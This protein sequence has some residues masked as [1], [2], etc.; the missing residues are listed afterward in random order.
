[1]DSRFTDQV[2]PISI[3]E[4]ENFVSRHFDIQAKAHPLGSERDQNFL[5]QAYDG[6]EYLLKITHPGEALDSTAFQTACLRHISAVDS[7]LPVPRVL[8]DRTGNPHVRATW[9]GVERTARMLTFLAGEPLHLGA[10]DA[11]QRR[12]IGETLAVLDAALASF[13]GPFPTLDIIWDMSRA[14]SIRP[15]ISAIPDAEQRSMVEA[16]LAAFENR[17]LP[18]QTG[19]ATQPIHNDFNPHNLLVSPQDHRQITGII[20]FGDIAVAPRIYDLAVAA[21]YQVLDG[22]H[23][24]QTASEIVAGYHSLT[25]LTETEVALLHDLIPMRLA[26]AVSITGWRAEMHPENR[27]YILRNSPGAWRA[28]HQLSRISPAE[29]EDY[30]HAANGRG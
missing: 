15:L 22:E 23:P 26:L 20:D 1:M 21:S 5:I 30:F 7:S 4:A 12:K 19:L 25:P 2:L 13:P 9:A 27:D 17:V 14:A 29:A 18:R 6:A 16:R 28:L 24:L 3:G 8:D 11:A 10:R